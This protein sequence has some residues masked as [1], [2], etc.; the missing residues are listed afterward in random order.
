MH[1]LMY[2]NRNPTRILLKNLFFNYFIM[3]IF[4]F[5]FEKLNFIVFS[6][7]CLDFF[8]VELQILLKTQ[9]DKVPLNFLKK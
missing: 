8:F 7:N 9:R 4:F 2:K 6:I 3:I 5:F 1:N